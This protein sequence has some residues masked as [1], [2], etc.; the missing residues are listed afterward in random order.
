MARPRYTRL[1]ATQ[2]ANNLAR[3]HG[4][5]KPF[6]PV[7][8]WTIQNNKPLKVQVVMVRGHCDNRESAYDY[9]ETE[10]R[11]VLS[12]RYLFPTRTHKHPVIVPFE[13]ENGIYHDWCSDPKK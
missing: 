7:E 12:S 4:C 13:D 10:D 2:Y 1:G 5:G 8:C 6:E 9:A 11:S 3:L